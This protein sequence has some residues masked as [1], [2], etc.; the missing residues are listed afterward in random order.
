LSGSTILAR[1]WLGVLLGL[2]LLAAP[3]A[4]RAQD[5]EPRSFS[6]APVGV[7]F[8]IAGYAYTSGGVSFDP[9]LPVTNAQLETSSAVLAYSR[10]L[11]LFGL[12]GK[13]DALVPYTWLSG[14]AMLAGQ[15][16]SRV[17]DGLGDPA[18]RLSVNLYGAPALTLREFA[19]YRQDLIVGARLT[20]T[21][22]IGQYDASRIVNLGSNRW[23]FRPELGVSQALGPLTVELT[24]G[25]TFFTD[26]TD[27]FNGRTRAQEPIYALRG[28]A[29]YSFRSGIW[30]S[31]DAI[32]FAG[33]RTRIDGEAN[34]DRLSNWRFGATVSVPLG[35]R[36]SV[37]VYASRGFAART[38]NDFDLIGIAL[39]Y[40]WGGGL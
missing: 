37:K 25:V 31:A 14:S 8:L 34:D 40:R 17:V 7:N 11:D 3:G 21:V 16:I 2:A 12:S 6:N 9:A 13:V 10:V 38:R 28:N 20:V 19:A 1:H 23:S 4:L 35:A 18:F 26:N 39:Q 29:V 36:Y 27:F 5:I 32:W 33:G 15:P 22:P 30:A 24:G